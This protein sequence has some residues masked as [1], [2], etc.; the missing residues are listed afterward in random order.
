MSDIGTLGESSLHAALK[1][2][3]AQPDDR[4]EVEI[5]GYF[6]DVVRDE[7]L[8][9]IQT[10]NFSSF[11]TK[12][13]QLLPHH[14]IQVVYPVPKNKWIVRVSADGELVS[15]RKSP[16]HGRF[17]DVFAELVRIPH[18]LDHDNLTF[19]LLLTEQEEIWLDD[20]QGSW[21]RK[22][23][24]I[25]D[26]RLLDVVAERTLI[27]PSDFLQLLPADLPHPFTNRQLADL[28]NI[29][30]KVAQQ[31]TYTLRHCGAITFIGKQGRANLHEIA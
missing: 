12:L 17:L 7:L 13:E 2:W 23:W 6:I 15:R 27:T 11:K 10:G 22:Y 26:H 8:I 28:G 19:R 31:L 21:R 18:L 29:R 14:P 20:G 24:S 30:L 1:A 16:K 25:A 4:L 5:D 3:V 9:E